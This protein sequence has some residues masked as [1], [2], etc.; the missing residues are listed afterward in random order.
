MKVFVDTAYLIAI[1]NPDDE[2]ADAAAIAHEQLAGAQLVTTEEVLTE[3]LNAMADAGVWVRVR[4][5]EMALKIVSSP[6]LEVIAQSHDS[7]LK[8][9]DLYGRRRDKGYSLTDCISMNTM[10]GLE[11]RQVLTGDRHFRQEGFMTLL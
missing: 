11:I 7:F 4:A 3:F 2:L 1:L 6:K 8:G 5:Y 10:R 9:L